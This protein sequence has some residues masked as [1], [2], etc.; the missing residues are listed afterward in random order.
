MLVTEMSGSVLMIDSR[1]TCIGERPT[2]VNSQHFLLLICHELRE[3]PLS[4]LRG[5][6]FM[7]LIQRFLARLRGG[8]GQGKYLSS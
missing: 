7:L 5:G 3:K 6:M 8:V 1:G 2:D 4:G